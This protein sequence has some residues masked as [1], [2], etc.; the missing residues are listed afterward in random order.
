MSYYPG[1]PVPVAGPR[2]LK[3][4]YKE[5]ADYETRKA[6]EEHNRAR[7]RALNS[8]T[9]DWL[10]GLQREQQQAELE[11]AHEAH[12][13]QRAKEDAEAVKQR[14]KDT[15]FRLY[16]E[17]EGD[18]RLKAAMQYARVCGYENGYGFSSQNN[19]DYTIKQLQDIN[20]CP[21]D[22]QEQWITI[23]RKQLGLPRY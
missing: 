14:Q 18:E 22:F 4:W 17:S 3:R 23:R 6:Q 16:W 2:A 11:Q 13:A 7:H 5:K 10:M 20:Q 12:R 8:A 15:Y 1:M 21:S 19:F 9:Q